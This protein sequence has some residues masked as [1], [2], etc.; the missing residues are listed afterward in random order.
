MNVVACME[1]CRWAREWCRAGKGP[2]VLEFRTYRYHGHSMSDPGLTYRTKDEVA[3]IRKRNDPIEY[4]RAMLLDNF[5]VPSE[6]LK[7]IEKQI[8]V[9]V[10]A[11]AKDAE[12]DGVLT[13][14]QLALD[15]YSTGPPPYVRSSNHEESLHF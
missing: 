15:I 5:G 2:L 13:E 3:D 1:A 7:A 8:R 10:A 4:V 9:E 11:A 12:S 6:E 14:D